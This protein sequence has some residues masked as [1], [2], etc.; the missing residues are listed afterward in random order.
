MAISMHLLQSMGLFD[1][2][3]AEAA[4]VKRPRVRMGRVNCMLEVRGGWVSG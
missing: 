1:F 2:G 4:A 3:M